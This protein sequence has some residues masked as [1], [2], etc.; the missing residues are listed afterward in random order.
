MTGTD[1]VRVWRARIAFATEKR[2]VFYE[3]RGISDDGLRIGAPGANFAIECYRGNSRPPWWCPE[4]AWIHIGKLKAAIRAALPSLLYK[5]PQFQIYP[6]AKDVENGA[7]VAY[8]RSKAKALWLNHWWSESHGTKHTRNGIQNAFF[9][10]GVAKA[11][12]R[13]QFEDDDKRGVFARD[14]ATGEYELDEN[15]DPTLER[16]EFLYDEAGDVRRDG[17]GL[18][19]LHPGTVN[20]EE[21]FV[22]VIDNRNMLYDVDR[23]SDFFQ[24]NWVAEEWIRP[25]EDVKRD[26]RIPSAIR[27]RLKGTESVYGLRTARKSEAQMTAT[28]T[29]SDV[30][31]VQRDQELL[32]G[33]DIYDFQTGEYLVLPAEGLSGSNEEFMLEEAMPDGMEH[34]PYRFL[35][36][37]EDV[38]TEWYPVP[39][40]TDM[41]LVNQE[42]N[43]TRSQMFIHRE[44]TKT[45]YAILDG[46]F[47]GD[48]IDAEE[49]MAKWAHGP[50]SASVR[51][52]RLDGI[53]PLN[54]GQLDSSFM[55][56]VPNIA[57]DF[58]EVGGMP[59]EVRGVA[60]ADTATQ[61]SILAT[62]AETRNNDR[63]DNQVQTWLCEIGRVLLMSG[64]ANAEMDSLVVQKVVEAVGV[65]PFRAVKLSPAE[66]QGEFEVTIQVGS[67]QAKN[68]PRVLQQIATLMANLG[69]NPVLGLMKGLIRRILDGLG[70][71]PE[72]ANEIY[73]ASMAFLQSQQKSAPSG[74]PAAPAGPQGQALQQML[75]GIGNAAGGSPTGAPLN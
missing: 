32:R 65:A 1:K 38:G 2:R 56:A 17:D 3:G 15:G 47:S 52:T 34:G 16:G 28:A 70:L 57:D 21:W 48:G 50:D 74:S 9:D 73:D 23:G 8:E 4:D 37:T 29:T 66:L 12:Y 71:D 13:C 20:K 53:Q 44:H 31:A 59:G 45:R 51:V 69:Q 39:D 62:S 18:P 19:L 43:L 33:Y 40:A 25:L 46:T 11:G 72:L 75:G 27:K 7:D 35:K 36:F 58:N 68:D 30:E 67:T 26:T 10:I 42:Y 60:N 61:A 63:R 64:Q 24:H 54:K 22:E 55:Q 14:E 6:A 49:E 5:D 41:A